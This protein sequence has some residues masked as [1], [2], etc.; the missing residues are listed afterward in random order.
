LK[1]KPI[2]KAAA[3][4]RAWRE[5]NPG[6]DAA[7]LIANPKAHKLQNER[8]KRW[9]IEHPNYNAAWLALHP[10]NKSAK[11]AV[12]RQWLKTKNERLAGRPK[13]K[14]CEV[15]SKDGRNICF[16][17]CHKS[18]KFRGW[19][20][21]NRNSVL[22]YAKDSIPTLRKLITYLETCRYGG[23]GLVP[24]NKAVKRKAKK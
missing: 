15:C 24:K 16:D 7:W 14:R 6:Y 1:T 20:C 5:K 12:D 8:K 22:G 17:H 11:Y 10:R 21:S 13:P 2:S 18:Q 19:I 4:S 23:A 3:K 9:H